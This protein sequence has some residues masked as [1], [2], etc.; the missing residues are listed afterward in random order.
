MQLYLLPHKTEILLK[1][2]FFFNAMKPGVSEHSLNTVP[3]LQTCTLQIYYF[4]SMTLTPSYDSNTRTKFKLPQIQKYTRPLHH[5]EEITGVL[6]EI[7][8]SSLTTSE[9]LEDW[10]VVNVVFI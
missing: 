1:S 7:Y 8:V 3:R 4:H 10:R 5:L 2:L 9:V 6:A